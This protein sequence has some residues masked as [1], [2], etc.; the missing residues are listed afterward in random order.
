MFVCGLATRSF[1]H[2]HRDHLQQQREQSFLKISQTTLETKRP[3]DSFFQRHALRNG[4]RR[5]RARQQFHRLGKIKRF[6]D[7][8]QK[9]YSNNFLIVV[10]AGAVGGLT[11]MILVVSKFTLWAAFPLLFVSAAAL[12]VSALGL[13]AVSNKHEG[14]VQWYFVLQF[15]VMITVAMVSVV[16]FVTAGYV[17]D[18]PCNVRREGG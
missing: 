15:L 5:R 12:G 3:N 7:H 2:R 18:L 10:W 8:R 17:S 6:E 16:C 4:Q 1:T 11:L 14:L 13:L 9:L